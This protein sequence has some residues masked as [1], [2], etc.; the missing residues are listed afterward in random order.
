MRI[1]SLFHVTTNHFE[2]NKL[3]I[4]LGGEWSSDIN[5]E[6]VKVGINLEENS[7]N[8]SVW[9]ENGIVKSIVMTDGYDECENIELTEEEKQ[10]AIRFINEE[11]LLND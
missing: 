10:Y 9:V 4:I 2:N 3:D 5:D 7:S 1:S 8:I 11:K 6:L